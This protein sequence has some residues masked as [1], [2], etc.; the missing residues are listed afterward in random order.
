VRKFADHRSVVESQCE[1]VDEAH[2]DADPQHAV[3]TWASRDRE[4]ATKRSAESR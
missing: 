3:I 2:A 1:A 4:K